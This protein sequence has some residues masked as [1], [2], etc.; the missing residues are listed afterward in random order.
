[1][2]Q[3]P[4]YDPS[5][6]MDY[7][8]H[9]IDDYL[10]EQCLRCH[11]WSQGARVDGDYPASGWAACHVSYSNSGTYEGG[12]RAIDKKQKDARRRIVLPT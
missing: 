6:P 3:L 1:L 8:N 2:T 5:K 12:D 4:H 9:P 7:T 10:R 11:L